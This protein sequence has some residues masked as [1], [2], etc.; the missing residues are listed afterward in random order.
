MVR[1]MSPCRGIVQLHP[2]SA[3]H[4]IHR[5]M[6]LYRHPVSPCHGIVWTPTVT[7]PWYNCTDI[8]CQHHAIVLYGPSLSLCRGIVPT[9]TVTVPWYSPC[10]GNCTDIHCHRAMVLY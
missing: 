10:R 4:G 1:T 9:S 3:C 5:A 6:V 2:L 8:Q 7:V